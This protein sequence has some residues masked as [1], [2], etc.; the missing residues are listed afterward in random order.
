M[1]ASGVHTSLSGSFGVNTS[2]IDASDVHT[3]G[4][5][6]SCIEGDP[7]ADISGVIASEVKPV[8]V[9]SVSTGSSAREFSDTGRVGS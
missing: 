5:G 4:I 9:D 8:G 6:P 2:V 3:V 7:T 1:D